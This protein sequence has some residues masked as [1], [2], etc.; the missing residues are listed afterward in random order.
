MHHGDTWIQR[1]RVPYEK[2]VADAIDALGF[3]SG[4]DDRRRQLGE[5]LERKVSEV[6]QM[7]IVRSI[8]L[9]SL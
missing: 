5:E 4:E 9:D 2:S 6:S 7:P 3:R 1:L 8:A